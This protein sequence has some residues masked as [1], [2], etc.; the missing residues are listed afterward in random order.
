MGGKIIF[1]MLK[2]IAQRLIDEL[3]LAA[4]ESK[5]RAEGVAML[6]KKLAEYEA[7]NGKE[8]TSESSKEV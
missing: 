2:D 5:L 3:L 4:E 7:A 1:S 8:E 6:Y